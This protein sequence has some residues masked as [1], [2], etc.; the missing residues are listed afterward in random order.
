MATS[1]AH[2]T[3]ETNSTGKGDEPQPPTSSAELS[4]VPPATGD[5]RGD[6]EQ[7]RDTGDGAGGVQDGAGAAAAST[8]D[9]QASSQ[10]AGAVAAPS[11]ADD[12]PSATTP[13][14]TSPST[15]SPPEPLADE[16]PVRQVRRLPPPPKKGILRPPSSSHAA[17]SRFSFRRDFLQPFNTSYSRATTTADASLGAGAAGV[18]AG[19][20]G[21]VMGNAAATAGGFF[22][23][24]LK[25]LTAAA[26]PPEEPSSST[27]TS[28]TA[29]T[30]VAP[31]PAPAL[32][33]AAP[34]PSA[35]CVAAGPQLALPVA[36][37]KRVRFRMASLKLVYPINGG[38]LDVIAPADE[39]ATR[40]R[41][42]S[43]WRVR[44]LAP[45]GVGAA[46]AA[47]GEGKVKVRE[48]D[49]G[50]KE[51]AGKRW[52]GDE[53][54][55]LYAECCRTREEPGIE[56]VKRAFRENPAAPPKVL[57]LSNELLS[58]GAVEALSDLLAID[59][60]LKKLTLDHCG[61]DDE[62]LR[63]LLH[64]L[65]V[66]ASIPTVSLAGNKRIRA[67]GW[68][69]IATFLR[70]ATFLRYI[71]L[72]ETPIDRRAAEY[73]VQALAPAPSLPPPPPPPPSPPPIPEKEEPAQPGVSAATP[74]PAPHKKVA[75]PWDEDDDESDAEEAAGG[76]EA[77][78]VVESN[79]DAHEV[80]PAVAAVKEEAKVEEDKEEEAEAVVREPLFD[81]APLLKEDKSG[82]PAAVLS[83][84]L[85]NCG[86]RGPALE[87][88]AP[89]VRVS[90][91]KHISLRK[92]RINAAGAVALAVLIR[93]YP[94]SSD[95]SSTYSVPSAI[96]FASSVSSEHKNGAA[97]APDSAS[98]SSFSLE[99][100]NSVSARQRDRALSVPPR[101][102]VAPEPV[103]QDPEL[104]SALGERE[105]WRLSE[106]RLRLRKQ[107]D[108]LPRIGALL[109]LD[110]KGNDIRSGVTYIAQVLKRNR[111]LKVLNL[112][113]NKIDPQG[114]VALAEALK[115]NTT[116]E[117]LDMG[118][119]PCCGPPID[120]ILALR[121]AMMV[122]PSLKR[123]FL[124][125]T[126]LSSEGAIALAEFLPEA[127][128]LLHLDLTNNNVDIS[129]VLALS[130]SIKLN[131]TIRCLDI[132]IPFDDPD[133]SRLSQDLLETCVRNTELAQQKADAEARDA[134]AKRVV[135]AQ[136]IRKSALASNLEARQQ[137]EQRRA[138]RRDDALRAQGDIFAAA[139]ET[140]DV[141]SQLLAVEQAAGAREPSE[142]VRDALVQLQLAE[143]QLAEAFSGAR[144]V[145]QRERAEVLLTELASLLDL[146][147]NM[148]DRPPP[149][150][151]ASADAPGAAA[152][153]MIPA[154]ADL[155]QPPS[156]PTFS[157]Q[158]SDDSDAVAAGPAAAAVDEEAVLSS[159][160]PSL[161]VK[162]ATLLLPDDS[163]PSSSS[164]PSSPSLA[165]S[166]IESE[167]RAMVAEE[168]EM[169]RKGVALG[170]D[171]V[172]DESD[173]EGGKEVS[174]EELK[175]E[176]LET[177]VQRSPR[178]SFN[179][180]D[181]PRPS[182]A[183]SLARPPS[184]S[185]E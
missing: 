74:A 162:P 133:F 43:E 132:N 166:P 45:P 114:L 120:G 152:G 126:D 24:A 84:R 145:E 56:R 151:S 102:A 103:E 176:L 13:T 129:G 159:S 35:P 1:D 71:D 121:S 16:T 141:V 49:G 88:L 119:N 6:V 9:G 139:A 108:G 157:L 105:A 48:K 134:A 180:D 163:S 148:F 62:S 30:A 140:R 96:P 38:T 146:A 31:P 98:T 70:K 25:R 39:G 167:S 183:D 65:L 128:S 113:E 46:G 97:N 161:S 177:T 100:T 116:L 147:K 112:G 136:P 111:T 57:D 178:P 124:N 80:E 15:T 101:P 87:V 125:S 66:S 8:E 174:G 172:G 64:A 184:D 67:R 82:T 50:E 68:K 95:P 33:A 94:L 21:E 181:T 22:G 150:L 83:L 2:D 138:K 77:A 79:G 122:S 155:D 12:P 72:S 69:F 109:T 26:A 19:S 27:A 130:V 36:D 11:S 40:E 81:T 137:A 107:L 158:D 61:L 131:S 42:E 52:T 53:L 37:L 149:S 164:G 5:G 118:H 156:S 7:P 34:S 91:V 169:F 144:Q 59:F 106:A 41:V 99:V 143:A 28:A 92:N 117:T 90:E 171:E 175:K 63:P 182:L 4:E 170:V 123:V 93:D 73:L 29:P 75:G 58:R 168:G 86:L 3:L 55:R 14:T 115:F 44:H 10:V 173:D 32:P 47:G 76:T 60:G 154:P 51:G 185:V 85:E 23:S 142:V 127:H 18:G 110:V 17:S 165:R 20:V 160:S 153:L 104:V 135:V 54:L 89:G 78:S 179:S